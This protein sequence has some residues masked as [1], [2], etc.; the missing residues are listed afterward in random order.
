MSNEIVPSQP[1]SDPF[2]VLPSLFMRAAWV[3]G[4][5]IV[6]DKRPTLIFRLADGNSVGVKAESMEQAEQWLADC[7]AVLRTTRLAQ[8]ASQLPWPTPQ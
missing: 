7:G 2:I 8:V 4:I 1:D 3:A 5:N 6:D